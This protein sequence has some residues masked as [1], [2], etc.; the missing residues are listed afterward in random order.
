MRI[1]LKNRISATLYTVYGSGK[2]QTRFQPPPGAV[3]APHRKR[4][5][6][7]TCLHMLFEQRM[8]LRLLSQIAAGMESDLSWREDLVQEAIIHLWQKEIRCPGQSQAWYLRSCRFHLCNWLR[9]G[10]SVDSPKHRG[11]RSA[12]QEE[13]GPSEVPWDERTSDESPVEVVCGRE[14]TSLLSKWLTDRE[15]QVFDCLAD[16][17][18]ARE[19]A[20]YLKVSHTWVNQQRRRI[21]SLALQLGLVLDGRSATPGREHPEPKSGF[22]LPRQNT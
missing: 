19:T 7:A 20:K 15:K 3:L 12:T 6:E 21:A 13:D 2:Q 22:Q 9:H 5:T 10:R 18:S 8:I 14:I 1:F 16:G 17:F 4:L 11:A